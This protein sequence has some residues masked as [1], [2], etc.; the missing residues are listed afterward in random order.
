MRLQSTCRG[1]GNFRD[2]ILLVDSITM[3]RSRISEHY[4][5]LAP[6]MGRCGGQT[7][8]FMAARKGWG[9]EVNFDV[10]PNT[11]W[12]TEPTETVAVPYSETEALLSHCTGRGS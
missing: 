9:R 8:A 1:T 7:L 10:Y 11:A 4:E 5:L 2:I 6:T 12:P 3:S